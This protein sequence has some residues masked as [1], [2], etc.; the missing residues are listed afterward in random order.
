M[1]TFWNKQH[2]PKVFLAIV[3]LL[4]VHAITPAAAEAMKFTY[5]SY[6][7]NGGGSNIAIAVGFQPD[8]VIIKASNAQHTV[9]RTASMSGTKELTAGTALKT[10]RIVS[11]DPN[12]F[13]VGTNSEV[14]GNSGNTYYWMAFKDTGDGDLNVNSYGGDATDGHPITTGFQP[15]YVIVMSAGGGKAGQ[16]FDATPL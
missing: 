11:L 15:D 9:M 4:V 8:V 5:G 7:G 6:A 2:R 3:L 14:N 10:I 12:G 13:T 16:G 1:K